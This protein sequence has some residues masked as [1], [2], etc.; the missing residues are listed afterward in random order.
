MD[1]GNCF[2]GAT[3]ATT[4]ELLL[5]TSTPL[6]LLNSRENPMRV[7]VERGHSVIIFT[8]M[9]R[10][11]II[12]FTVEMRHSI[13][14]FESDNKAVLIYVTGGERLLGYILSQTVKVQTDVI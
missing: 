13:I 4:G 2:Q 1:S 9:M 3:E 5:S 14:I 7:T 12:T 10:Y 8:V 11:S 6:L